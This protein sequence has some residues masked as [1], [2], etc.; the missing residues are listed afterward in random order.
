MGYIV[1]IVLWTTAPGVCAEDHR[2][3]VYVYLCFAQFRL[4]RGYSEI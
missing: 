4:Q 1:V 2:S 3:Y